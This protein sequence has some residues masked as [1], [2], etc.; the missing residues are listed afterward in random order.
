MDQGATE[1]LCEV[2]PEATPQERVNA[3]VSQGRGFVVEFDRF[4]QDRWYQYARQG[5]PE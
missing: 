2:T 3:L 4:L 5:G 1:D